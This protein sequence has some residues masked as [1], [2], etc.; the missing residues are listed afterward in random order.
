[1]GN[2]STVGKSV[3]T[4]VWQIHVANVKGHRWKFNPDIGQIAVDTGELLWRTFKFSAFAEEDGKRFWENALKHANLEHDCDGWFEGDRAEAFHNLFHDAWDVF[5]RGE[6]GEV[7]NIDWVLEFMRGEAGNCGFATDESDHEMIVGA[8]RDVCF[9]GNVV[10]REV[11]GRMPIL[12]RCQKSTLAVLAIQFCQ[13][14]GCETF[15]EVFL[16]GEAFNETMAS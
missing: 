13:V 9:L 6:E 14:W 12:R 5:K 1:M 16:P 11:V 15:A 8:S 10:E 7:A 3:Q 2:H 4:L